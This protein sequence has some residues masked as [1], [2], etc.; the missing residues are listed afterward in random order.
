MPK[1]SSVSKLI[2]RSPSIGSCP[3]NL[4]NKASRILSL[5]TWQQMIRLLSINTTW[6]ILMKKWILICWIKRSRWPNLTAISLKPALKNKTNIWEE[7]IKLL[8]KWKR[9]VIKEAVRPLRFASH[10][11]IVAPSLCSSSILQR[12]QP[13]SKY[14]SN[15]PR[16]TKMV[17]RKTI[18]RSLKNKRKTTQ[19]LWK[20]CDM[21]WIKKA[22]GL[23]FRSTLVMCPVRSLRQSCD[24]RGARRA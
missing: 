3:L 24:S 18:A 12:L 23:T 11:Q 5:N 22:M 2:I 9:K 19:D 8:T 7:S 4:I 1:R 6:L 10:P 20:L 21:W 15:L 14:R 13:P 17:E 16:A